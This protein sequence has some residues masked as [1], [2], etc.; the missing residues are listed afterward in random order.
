MD[1]FM[2][3]RFSRP[4]LPV[5]PDRPASMRAYYVSGLDRYKTFFICI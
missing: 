3:N 1:N 4:A 2:D 5:L